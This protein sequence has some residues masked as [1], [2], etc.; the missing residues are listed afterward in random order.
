MA[1]SIQTISDTSDEGISLNT[2]INE[3]LS[4]RIPELEFLLF[5]DELDDIVYNKKY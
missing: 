5:M 4:E 1:V 3:I 2:R